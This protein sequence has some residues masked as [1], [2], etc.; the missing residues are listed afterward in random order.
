MIRHYTGPKTITLPKALA[1][2]AVDV[3]QIVTIC[4]D[5]LDGADTQLDENGIGE[6]RIMVDLIC[7]DVDHMVLAC[8][9]LADAGHIVSMRP[10][11]RTKHRMGITEFQDMTLTIRAFA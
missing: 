11:Y 5:A 1:A 7:L 2:V 9:R 6:P 8:D 3:A 10:D 4:G